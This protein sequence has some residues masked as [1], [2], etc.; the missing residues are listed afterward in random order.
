MWILK[1]GTT[2]KF[3]Q[4][5]QQTAPPN[6]NQLLQFRVHLNEPSVQYSLHFIMQKMDILLEQTEELE[7]DTGQYNHHIHKH[8]HNTTL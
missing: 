5:E 2:Q 8:C 1:N 7:P 3:R 4:K 6:Y